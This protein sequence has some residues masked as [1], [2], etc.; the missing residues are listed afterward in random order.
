M[1]NE[2]G[3]SFDGVKKSDLREVSCFLRFFSFVS[4]DRRL[5]CGAL[6]IFSQPKFGN[7]K[8]HADLRLFGFLCCSQAV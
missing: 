1:W 7:W 6:G 2:R 3:L 5:L 4:Q 8:P